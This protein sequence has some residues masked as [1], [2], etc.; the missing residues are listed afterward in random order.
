MS[1]SFVQ[2]QIEHGVLVARLDREKIGEY[3]S[4]VIRAEV[5][6]VAPGA[7]WR[8]VLDL[9]DVR[10]VASAG[11]GAFVTLNKTCKD[12]G[13]RLA[14]CNM[15][16]MLRQVFEMTKLHRVLT[17]AATRDAAIKAVS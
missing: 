1:S 2:S 15:D 11:L 14:L 9:S 5:E 8:V 3:E 10:M 17:I 13:G 4:P 16:E 7:N 12:K 6:S